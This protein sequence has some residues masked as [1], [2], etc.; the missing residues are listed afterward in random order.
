[1]II[2]NKLTP[3]TQSDTHSKS[4]LGV[5]GRKAFTLIELLVVIAIIAILAAI[6]FPVFARARENARKSSCMSNLKQIGLAELQYVQDYDETYSGS[7]RDNPGTDRVSYPE[8]IFPYIKSTQIFTCPSGGDAQR[9]NNNGVQDCTP[10]PI[11]C[12]AFINYSY[13]SITQFDIGNSNGDRSNNP[14][15]KITDPATTI[16]IMD[17]DGKN[18]G[19]AAYYNT[20][21]SNETDIVGSYY[22]N[23]WVGTRDTSLTP[24]RRHL[25]GANILW[26]DGHVKW[27]R[28]TAYSNG[29]PYYWYITKPAVP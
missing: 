23:T 10:N 21:R 25:E 3:V 18:N 26:Y 11:T 13:N 19:G 14:A 12:K 24:T 29:S 2:Y 22:G 4:P 5:Q 15:A 1:M 16:L 20:W 9:F 7:F 8:M 28:N 17:G 27:L 6:L